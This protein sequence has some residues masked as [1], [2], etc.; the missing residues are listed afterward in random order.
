MADNYTS[1][2]D[3]TQ[4]SNANNGSTYNVPSTNIKIVDYENVN[5]IR[6]A[7]NRGVKGVIPKPEVQFGNLLHLT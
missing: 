6:Q 5:V 1:Y 2:K 3:N 7:C 4:S